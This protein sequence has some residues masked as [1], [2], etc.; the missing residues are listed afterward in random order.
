MT[1]VAR[2]G[3]T[4]AREEEKIIMARSVNKVILLGNVGKDP[5]IRNHRWRGR[6]LQN[7]SVATSGRYKDKS[8]EWQDQT[9]GTT[10]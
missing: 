9:D 7:L 4:K 6:W 5:E 2:V 10:W 1:K 8:G 3:S